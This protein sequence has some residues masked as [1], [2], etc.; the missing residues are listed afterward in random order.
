MSP[1]SGLVPTT[2]IRDP[3]FSVKAQRNALIVRPS[4]VSPSRMIGRL[5]PQAA[6]DH[7]DL[8]AGGHPSVEQT[9]IV[10]GEASLR[11]GP[12]R[13]RDSDEPASGENVRPQPRDFRGSLLVAGE[14]RGV[15]RHFDGPGRN[16][17]LHR[18]LELANELVH[19][20]SPVVVGDRNRVQRGQRGDR[21]RQVAPCGHP[22]ALDEHRDD[23]QLLLEG[24]RDLE[25]DD[26]VPIVE[27]TTG[28][29][30]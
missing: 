1:P 25:A 10:D 15:S 21:P 5:E 28:R 20:L 12:G 30:L 11:G 24:S 29:S 26:I 7:V 8:A 4:L 2:R 27:P 23:M 14:R 9:G 6:G 18:R 22:S 13:V 16:A 17:G 3:G 19:A